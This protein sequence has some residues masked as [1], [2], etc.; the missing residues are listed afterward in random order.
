MFARLQ[1]V[2]NEFSNIVAHQNYGVARFRVF[3][4]H[5]NLIAFT[6]LY[7]FFEPL[8]SLLLHLDF[9]V[10]TAN[11]ISFLTSHPSFMELC[12]NSFGRMFMGHNVSL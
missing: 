9:C 3:P 1:I 2:K 10:D 7:S 5:T 11:R 12:Q 6:L 8:H 4:N